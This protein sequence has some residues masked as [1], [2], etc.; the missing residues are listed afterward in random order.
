ML[1]RSSIHQLGKDL[2][3]CFSPVLLLQL[4]PTP[5]L[6]NGGYSQENH[7]WRNSLVC[8]HKTSYG[9][10]HARMSLFSDIPDTYFCL[11]RTCSNQIS[12]VFPSTVSGFRFFSEKN[13]LEKEVRWCGR[14]MNPIGVYVCNLIMNAMVVI[15]V[16]IKY[17]YV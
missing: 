10:V 4:N 9:Q 7:L 5:S 3:K 16:R 12:D 14:I 11:R 8:T 15:L 6:N 1:S 13:K 2:Q 17:E